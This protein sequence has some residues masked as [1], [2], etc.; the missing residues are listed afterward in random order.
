MNNT[1]TQVLSIVTI[2]CDDNAVV[3]N[4][5][6]IPEKLAL[7]HS[8]LEI[9]PKHGYRIS[10]GTRV[11]VDMNYKRQANRKIDRYINK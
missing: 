7:R 9:N 5:I 8:V 1:K 11:P 6:I 2:L 3:C 10:N 4:N